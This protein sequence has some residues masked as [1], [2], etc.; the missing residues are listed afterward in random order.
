MTTR[1]GKTTRSTAR[2]LSDAQKA[3][4]AVRMRVTGM[5]YREIAVVQ[6]V[7]VSTVHERVCRA[8]AAVPVEAVNELRALELQRLDD[9]QA[10]LTAIASASHPKVSRGRVITGVDDWGPVLRALGQLR[11]VSESR[12]KLLG[13]DAP[14]KVDLHVSDEMTAEIERLAAEL[15]VTDPTA[16]AS[17]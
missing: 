10:R 14:A 9:L 5:T 4:E 17:E 3:A 1:T 8:L 15:G 16:R 6:H 2:A 13:L 11:Q 12:R 7:A